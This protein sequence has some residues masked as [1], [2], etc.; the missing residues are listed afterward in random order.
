MG[1]KLVLLIEDDQ[2]LRESTSMF[3]KEEG[4]EVLLAKNGLEGVEKAMEH[5]PDLILCDIS[6]PRMNGYEVFSIISQNSATSFIPFIYLSAKT[7]REDI[8]VGMQMGAD[9]YITK[10][11]DYDELLKAI[12]LRIAKREKLIN[13]TESGFKAMLDST[14]TGIMIYQDDKVSFINSK[15][16]KIFGYSQD[17]ILKINFFDLVQKEYQEELE[18]KV[19]RCLRGIQRS[20]NITFKANTNSGEVVNIDCWGGLSLINGNNAL[21]ANLINIDEYRRKAES[22]HFDSAST[23]LQEKTEAYS[24]ETINSHNAGVPK[25][26]HNL[27]GREIEVLQH[28]CQGYTN[29]EIADKLF[30]SVRTVDTHRGNILSKTGVANTAGMVV[31]AIKHNLFSLEN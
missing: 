28:I 15:L 22:Q 18:N 17:E 3:L 14:L 6:M 5:I 1:K 11:F 16:L 29:Q 8:R 10:P 24:S 20:F 2:V 19:R 27:T 26:P 9:D 7:E 13:A 30:L 23:Y 25:N 12:E 31:Y 21:I 4:Y